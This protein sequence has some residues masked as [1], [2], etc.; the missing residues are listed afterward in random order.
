MELPG[1]ALGDKE[2]SMISG[3]VLKENEER[4]QCQLP[5]YKELGS[6]HSHPHKRKAVQT[7]NQ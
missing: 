7:A 3:R 1:E 4:L 5:M 6:C 2:D